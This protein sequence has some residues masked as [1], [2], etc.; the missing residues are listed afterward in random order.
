MVKFGDSMNT[1]TL[2]AIILIV[3]ALA[4]TACQIST[5]GDTNTTPS[6]RTVDDI[7]LSFGD[8]TTT[9]STNTAPNATPPTVPATT[10]SS[11]NTNTIP[12]KQVKE[13]GLVAFNLTATDP[14]G[15]T[16]TY[17]YSAPLDR[18]G[19]WQT[20][21]GDAG[22]YT[23]II[24]V[25]DGQAQ[26]S[27]NVLLIVESVNTPP[28]LTIEDSTISVE[29]GETISLNARAEDTDGD[30]VTITYSG[31][32]NTST[33]T[34]T[35]N[36]AGE[37]TVTISATDG[38][39]TVVKTVSVS[40]THTNKAPVLERISDITVT[41]GD[42]V[43]ITARATD[44]NDD[45][46]SYTFSQP[47]TPDGTWSTRKGDEGN[48]TI[49]VTAS[50][51][52][53]SATRTLSVTVLAKNQPPVLTILGTNTI[54][55]TEGDTITIRYDVSDPNGDDVRVRFSGF[56]TSESYTATY[57]DAGEHTVTISAS[58]GLLEVKKY[59]QITVTNKNR[60]P[61]F[62]AL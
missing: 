30:A 57:D 3:S 19:T 45:T 11:A 58:D 60:A 32:M 20:K 42:Q 46:L 53:L 2:A 21:K 51:G 7:A 59:I 23:I 47:I 29:S 62:G 6:G 38:K 12:I 5:T 36:D 17:T 26:A 35:K 16:L 13:G 4:L 50:D 37:H 25:S 9:P 24:T 31:W 54:T 43:L 34:T 22:N 49:T 56:M 55:I 27:Q 1:Y 14:D 61:I 44:P 8:T 41:E 15:D 18:T 48:Y 40:V 33:K 52:S 39:A 28:Q 10:P